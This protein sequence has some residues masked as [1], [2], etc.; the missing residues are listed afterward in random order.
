MSKAQV[1][2]PNRF[3][4]FGTILKPSIPNSSVPVYYPNETKQL[5]QILEQDHTSPIGEFNFQKEKY[6]K[7]NDISKTW[8][9]YEFILVD[10]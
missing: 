3:E 6:F 7:S 1:Q 4:V 8:K 5:I 10:M 2:T 9:F